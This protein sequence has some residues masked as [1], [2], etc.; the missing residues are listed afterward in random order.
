MLRLEKAFFIL[1]LALRADVL[2][3]LM[4]VSGTGV[5]GSTERRSGGGDAG[6]AL[7]ERLSFDCRT[8]ALPDALPSV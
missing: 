6:A 4:G 5:G 2:L 8:K 3:L 7:S 1:K